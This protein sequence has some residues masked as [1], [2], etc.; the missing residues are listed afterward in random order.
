MAILGVM[1]RLYTIFEA[2]FRMIFFK[3]GGENAGSFVL[4]HTDSVLKMI[5]LE[6]DGIA[7]MPIEYTSSAMTAL[8]KY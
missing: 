1:E 4:F 7:L 3:A 2:N 8:L 5:W 6:A